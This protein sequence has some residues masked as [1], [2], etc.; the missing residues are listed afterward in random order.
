MNVNFAGLTLRCSTLVCMQTRR[1]RTCVNAVHLARWEHRHSQSQPIPRVATS[2]HSGPWLTL[3]CSS[4]HG[5]GQR[6]RTDSTEVRNAWFSEA[7]CFSFLSNWSVLWR[8]NRVATICF[9]VKKKRNKA[10]DFYYS[11]AVSDVLTEAK[12]NL[13][14]AKSVGRAGLGPVLLRVGAGELSKARRAEVEGSLLTG[15]VSF[16][17]A[18]LLGAASSTQGWWKRGDWFC[19][20]SDKLS[21]IALQ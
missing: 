15:V 21:F 11:G 16:I 4:P 18:A 9:K 7:A 17:D 2:W 12:E 8:G 5:H 14:R 6:D 1:K 13:A 19:F 20:V 3:C 10:A